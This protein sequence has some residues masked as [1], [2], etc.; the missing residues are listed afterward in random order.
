MAFSFDGVDDAL[1][2][3][4]G[5]AGISASNQLTICAAFLADSPDN[6]GVIVG[7]GS[8]IGASTNVLQLR[9]VPATVAGDFDLRVRIETDMTQGVWDLEGE[10]LQFATFYKTAFSWDGD[11]PATDPVIYLDGSSR[12]V[13]EVT[14]PTGTYD[15]GIDSVAIGEVTQEA[16]ELTGDV[17]RVAFFDRQ[18]NAGE[19]EGL[20]KG[21]SPMF[22]RPKLYWKLNSLT[23]VIQGANLT[24][25]NNA[26]VVADPPGFRDPGM[27][28]IFEA[29]AAVVAA[30]SLFP[31]R[32]QNTLVR[33]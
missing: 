14:T 23:E 11:S 4:D 22:Y 28:E 18:L 6:N 12:T 5:L 19:L 13:T 7:F 16:G 9:V 33:M 17:S 27:Q 21:F 2:N 26:V 8:G 15:S 3:A 29:G 20:S 24:V 1:Q 32:R 10:N 30:A 25:K 31:P